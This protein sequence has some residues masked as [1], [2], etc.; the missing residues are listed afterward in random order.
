[1]TLGAFTFLRSRRKL[2]VVNVLVAVNTV[3]ECQRFLKITAGVTGHARHI[4]MLSQQGIFGARMIKC[5]LRRKFFPGGGAVAILAL[6]FERATMGI[7]VTIDARGKF[8][9]LKP[10]G[11]AR[12][13]RAVA[14]FAGH[15]NVQPRQGIAGFRMIKL[16]GG[17]P[18]IHVMATLA[19]R[20][21]LTLVVILMATYAIG[22][23]SEI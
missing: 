20:P 2:P 3:C 12:N 22:R 18:V 13:I 7:A 4:G 17:F 15:L 8:H 1:M 21:E 6:L 23:Q 10:R 5:E 11:P 16:F 14:F 9:I 19:I